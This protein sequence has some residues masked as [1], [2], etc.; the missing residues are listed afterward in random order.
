MRFALW[1]AAIVAIGLGTGGGYVAGL[2]RAGEQAATAI[3]LTERCLA[4]M[5][6]VVATGWLY[7]AGLVA[8][9]ATLGPRLLLPRAD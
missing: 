7:D 9:Q 4:Q 3:A 6:S 8:R 5:R 2:A 1:L